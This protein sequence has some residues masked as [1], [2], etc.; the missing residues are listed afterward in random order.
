MQVHNVKN[1]FEHG[2]GVK[3][4]SEASRKKIG[5]RVWNCE[6]KYEKG[7]KYLIYLRTSI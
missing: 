7:N 3:M 2:T 5:I 6:N 1:Q 4:A